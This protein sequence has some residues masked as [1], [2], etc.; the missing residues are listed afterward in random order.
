M[1][2]Q[3]TFTERA[4]FHLPSAPTTLH[5]AFLDISL[6]CS[7]A[8]QGSSAF[9][10]CLTLTPTGANAMLAKKAFPGA[11][12]EVIIDISKRSATAHC[13]SMFHAAS[14]PFTSHSLA[15]TSIHLVFTSIHFNSP[16]FTLHSLAFTCIHIYL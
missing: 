12:A 13:G 11:S 8:T 7:G 6:H 3:F 1:P 16:P 2:R 9:P 15:F 14:P 4:K 10:S 5:T